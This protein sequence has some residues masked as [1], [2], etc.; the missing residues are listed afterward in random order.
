MRCPHH[1]GGHT[2]FAGGQDLGGGVGI[3][4]AH[5]GGQAG[6]VKAVH[7]RARGRE[8]HQVSPIRGEVQIRPGD[9][10]VTESGDDAP[11][12]PSPQSQ[13]AQSQPAQHG[14]ESHLRAEEFEPTLSSRDEQHVGDPGQS[15]ADNVDDLGVQHVAPQQ[16]FVGSQCLRQRVDL[17]AGHLGGTDGEHHLIGSDI[18]DDGPGQHQGGGAAA[19]DHQ[20]L[21]ELRP[22]LI[23][24]AHR[25]VGEPTQHPAVGA[26][27]IPAGDSGEQQH[28]VKHAAFARAD[29]GDRIESEA[30]GQQTAARRHLCGHCGW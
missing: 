18:G 13:P 9:D 19:G 25:Q 20:S 16:D 22:G 2:G 11:Q 6:R 12:S 27:H 15:L 21:D 26:E 30:S 14:A 8:L 4:P 17:E 3:D 5:Q 29:R 10:V 23:A 7:G 28:T 1:L 24:E